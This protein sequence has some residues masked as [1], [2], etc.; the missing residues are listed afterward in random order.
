MNHPSHVAPRKIA[1]IGL[2]V[3]AASVLPS[4]CS[5][6]PTEAEAC[7]TATTELTTLEAAVTG[8]GAGLATGDFYGASAQ[9]NDAREHFQNAAGSITD[10]DVRSA[11]DSIVE[12][13]AEFTTTVN[14]LELASTDTCHRQPSV[15]QPCPVLLR[16]STAPAG[17]CDVSRQLVRVQERCGGG[18]SRRVS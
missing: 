3:L 12:S 8:A 14:E 2:S 6:P 15:T 16:L 7:S 10:P 9:L 17:G 1:G 5:T 13:V 18:V 4:E 11:F